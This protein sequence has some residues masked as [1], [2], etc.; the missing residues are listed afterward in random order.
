MQYSASVSSHPEAGPP[1]FRKPTAGDARTVATWLFRR[2]ERVDMHTLATHL[3]IGRSTL[4]RWVGDRE[5]LMDQVI[6]ASVGDI[7]DDARR[8]AVGGGVD[9]VLDATRRFMQGCIDFQPL[10]TFARREPNLALRVLLD[11]DGLVTAALARNLSREVAAAAPEVAVP[12]RTFEVLA[13][14]ATALLWA[15]VAASRDP[16]ID[17]TIDIMRTVLS[18]HARVAESPGEEADRL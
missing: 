12:Q 14:A 10:A 4:Y 1:S 6:L 5:K 18:A 13:L 3:D 8:D 11:P 15:H 16:D 9:R 17:A 7:W 2:G